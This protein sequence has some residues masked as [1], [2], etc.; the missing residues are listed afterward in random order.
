M[1]T[2]SG[3]QPI[4]LSRCN[5]LGGMQVPLGEPCLQ[6]IKPA[7]Q[8]DRPVNMSSK[9]S[10]LAAVHVQMV[11]VP[12]PMVSYCQSTCG[13]PPFVA[14]YICMACHAHCVL[15]MIILSSL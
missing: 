9:E 13:P 11:P 6:V 15:A 1:F 8:M 3:H 4:L 7:A 14:C 2:T 12:S 5:L 10:F